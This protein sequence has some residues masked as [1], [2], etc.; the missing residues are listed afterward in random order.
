[1]ISRYHFLHISCKYLAFYYLQNKAS[2]PYH[3]PH[4]IKTKIENDQK[5]K[6]HLYKTFD[7]YIT[8]KYFIYK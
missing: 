7:R 6:S 8:L 5:L 3:D 2:H 1:M 4:I